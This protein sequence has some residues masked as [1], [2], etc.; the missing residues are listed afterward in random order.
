MAEDKQFTYRGKTLDELKAMSTEQFSELLP[1][2]LRRKVKRGFGEQELKLIEKVKLGEKKIKTHC[3]DYFVTPD[4][5][6]L[7]LLIYNGKE[8]TEVTIVVEMIA[9]RLGELAPTRKIATHTTM[10]AKKTVT[11]K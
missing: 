4:M 7:K 1:S 3:R 8:F 2:E 11:R 10:G 6:G 5:V 9:L